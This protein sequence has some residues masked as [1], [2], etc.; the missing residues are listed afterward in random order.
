MSVYNLDTFIVFYVIIA[1]VLC[2]AAFIIYLHG[3]IASTEKCLMM[4]SSENKS[5]G[6]TKANIVMILLRKGYILIHILVNS[7]NKYND[8]KQKDRFC[9]S[10][11][12]NRIDRILSI[13]GKNYGRHSF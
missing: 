10:L 7:G 13:D 9:K 4:L 5:T 12:K 11:N 2:V 3:N 8:E 1:F 6:L